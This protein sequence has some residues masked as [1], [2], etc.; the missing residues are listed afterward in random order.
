[1][2]LR[3]GWSRGA[4]GIEAR[5]HL[6]VSRSSAREDE[7]AYGGA[8][9]LFDV[10]VGACAAARREH[11]VSPGACAGYTLLRSEGRGYGVSDPGAATA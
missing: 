9:D 1:L 7:P 6:W 5:G 10:G 11:V 3:L 8:F 4:I 2:G